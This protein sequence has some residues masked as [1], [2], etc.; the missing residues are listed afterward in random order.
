MGFEIMAV[1][2]GVFFA[3]LAGYSSTM[4]AG[5]RDMLVAVI[6]AAIM[7]AMAVVSM[8]AGRSTLRPSVSAR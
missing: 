2:Y 7:A 3:V 8:M 5:R 6:V 4:I 1:L